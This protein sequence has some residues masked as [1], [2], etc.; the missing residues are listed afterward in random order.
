[1]NRETELLS[2]AMVRYA[3]SCPPTL[4]IDCPFAEE[5]DGG[6]TCK[7][8]CRD[9][10]VRL[11]KPG[12]SG[13]SI[14][15]G[16]LFDARQFLLSESTKVPDANWHTS[17]LI[18]RL[19][20]ALLHPPRNAN[21][22]HLLKREI[23]ITN[24][25][26]YLGHRGFDPSRL[27][28]FGLEHVLPTMVTLWVIDNHVRRATY[29]RDVTPAGA[30]LG[31]FDR[32]AGEVTGNNTGQLLAAAQRSGFLGWVQRWLQQA[33]LESVVSWNPMEAVSEEPI[34]DDGR[35]RWMVDRFKET[36]LSNWSDASLHHEYLY[37]RGMREAPVPVV[38]MI[39]RSVTKTEVSQEIARRTVKGEGSRLAEVTTQSLTLLGEGRRREAAA[40]FDAAR[41]LDPQDSLAHNN[42]GFCLTPDDPAEALRALGR[43]EELDSGPGA[44]NLINQAVA[45][46]RMDR[47]VDA[48]DAANRAHV[49]AASRSEVAWLWKDLDS[50][51]PIICEVDVLT[52][53]CEFALDIASQVGDE[54][55]VE[56]W[57]SRLQ[58]AVGDPMS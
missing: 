34:T 41:I 38:E 32:H 24:S 17:S 40:L 8:Q 30:W 6:R 36:Y 18:Q 45:L 39:R 33:P 37:L 5:A 16:P 2:V 54:G 9:E 11:S 47:R 26:A 14:F 58:A 25:L 12:H 4:H 28:R 21:G 15:A 19:H 57:R 29:E 27:V 51:D 50:S 46:G 44:V 48:L 10:I 53:V 42:Y 31:V 43:A 1:M 20:S 56:Q 55:Q 35:A 22:E 13:V 7:Q 49:E 23:D 52:Y 3:D